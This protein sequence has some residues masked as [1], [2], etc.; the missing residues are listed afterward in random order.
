MAFYRAITLYIAE[1]R[2]WT[3]EIEDY[4]RWSLDYDI[5]LKLYYFG[6][7]MRQQLA[8]NAGMKRYKE[9][10]LLNRLPEVFNL[11]SVQALLPD[12]PRKSIL[13]LLRQWKKREY[14]SYNED[15][16]YRKS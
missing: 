12:N 2:Q 16:T 6:E 5:F 8:E 13:D 15:G 3:K 4:V 11:E 1:G 14:I 9:T 10:N 7:M